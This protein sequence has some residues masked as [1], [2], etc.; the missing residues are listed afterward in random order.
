MKKTLNAALRITSCSL[1]LKKR[2][3][4]LGILQPQTRTNRIPKHE[5]VRIS[6]NISF[7]EMC[8]YMRFILPFNLSM[9]ITTSVFLVVLTKEIKKME[10]SNE[11]NQ[12]QRLLF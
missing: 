5:Q 12:S 11:N 7:V 9:P 6:H 1:R 4:A 8:F 10:V 3:P 2:K